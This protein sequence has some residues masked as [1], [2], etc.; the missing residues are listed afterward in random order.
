MDGKNSLDL[1]AE[2]RRKKINELDDV[3]IQTEIHKGKRPRNFYK[4][5]VIYWTISGYM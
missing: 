5:S 1:I 2:T 3:T 4:V